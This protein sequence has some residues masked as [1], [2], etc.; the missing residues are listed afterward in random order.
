LKFDAKIKLLQEDCTNLRQELDQALKKPPPPSPSLTQN[1]RPANAGS[2]WEYANKSVAAAKMY[3]FANSQ[4]YQQMLENN[5]RYEEALG[6]LQA[7]LELE[8]TY[9][10]IVEKLTMG[11]EPMRH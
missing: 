10:F 3:R 11:S 8:K 4:M 9:V 1:T 5:Q 7:E 6:Q 2:L